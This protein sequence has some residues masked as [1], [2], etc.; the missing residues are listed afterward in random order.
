MSKRL[1]RSEVDK[2][3]GGVCGGLGDYFDI[4]PTLIRLIFVLLSVSGGAGLWAYLILW[5]VVPSQSSVNLE[6][7][8]VIKENKEEIKKKVSETAK[9]VKTEVKSD[10]KK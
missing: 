8:E 2:M 1:Y 3:L 4:D 7:E 6:S 10:T 9:N 5:I